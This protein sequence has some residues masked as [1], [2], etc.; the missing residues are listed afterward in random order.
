[1]PSMSR[2]LN[3]GS[4]IVYPDRRPNRRRAL[5]RLGRD[6][7]GNPAR[8]EIL[9]TRNIQR[10]RLVSV[11]ISQT[12]IS[13][14]PCGLREIP[15]RSASTEGRSQTERLLAITGFASEYR[16]AARRCL[17]ARRGSSE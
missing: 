4:S 2:P 14:C 15:A 16:S 10:G 1:M 3:P 6:K 8:H 17:A 5:S 9:A 13:S 11:G 7:L 12:V